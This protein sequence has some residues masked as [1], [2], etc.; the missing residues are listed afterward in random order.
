MDLIHKVGIESCKPASTPCKPH[1]Q[2][3]VNEGKPLTGPTLYRSLVG[4]LQYLTFIRP[5]TA[6]VVNSVCQFMKNSI[7]M[8]LD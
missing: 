1:N 7:D 5:N 8:H 4:S 2:L 3:L 6:F